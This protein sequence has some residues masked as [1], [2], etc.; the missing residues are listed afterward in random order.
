M[1]DRFVTVT[2]PSTATWTI[3]DSLELPPAVKVPVARLVGPTG[4]A[5][6]PADLG[7]ATA[8][9]GALAVSASQPGH[10][11]T[12]DQT[13]DTATRVAMTPAER[14]AISSLAS[15]YAPAAFGAPS[16]LPAYRPTWRE[17]FQT[18]HGWA[19]VFT[20]AVLT[21][22]TTDYLLG[23]ESL[24][25]DI[26]GA[27]VIQK[28][29]L[30]LDLT[31]LALVLTFRINSLDVDTASAFRVYAAASSELAAYKL[32]TVRVAT[33]ASPWF[34]HGEWVTVTLPWEAGTTTGSPNR[35]A[36]DTLRIR[37]SNT[38]S[39]N[40]Q[41]IGTVPVANRTGSVSFTFDDGYDSCMSA[42]RVLGARG[43]SATLYMIPGGAGTA[44]HLTTANLR[45]L[46]DVYGWDIEAHGSTTY[47]TLTAAQMRTEWTATRA[48]FAA[49]GL[50]LPQHL[51]YV[52][53]QSN[54]T[55][56][57]TAREFFAS[58][59]TITNG[60]ESHPPAMPYRTRAYSGV[61]SVAGGTSIAVAQAAISAAVAGGHHVNL[62]FHRITAGAATTTME[63]SEADLGT[64]ADYAVNA[65]A[66]IRTVADL[67]R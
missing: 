46:Q 8:A 34:Q 35:A 3:P 6:T 20:G 40:I 53:G 67:Y 66:D 26:T 55:V 9:Q 23:T 21:Q 16:R 32:W 28:S 64:L 24:R 25:V 44:G 60:V 29:G 52:G 42:A 10:T 5:A 54:A 18:G 31:G 36:I 27:G 62:V 43:I 49:Q 65:G 41:A 57:A 19:D 2:D 17:L 15:T 4:A 37:T 59:R 38:G 22:D 7:A 12:L 48:W 51:A 30:A 13:A 63:C 45:T 56:V 14:T 50:G 33:D 47:T 1:T 11:H 39:F 58:A 61:S